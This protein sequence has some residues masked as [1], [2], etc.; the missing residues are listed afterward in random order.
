M[1]TSSSCCPVVELRQYTLHPGQREALIALFDRELVET[2]EAVGMRVI[3]QF[4]DIDRPDVFTWLRGFSDMP[5]RAAALQAFYDGPVWAAHRDAANRTKLTF[6]NVRLLRPALNGSGFALHGV[7]RP[8]HGSTAVPRELIVCSICTLTAPAAA[9]FSDLF[10]REI[11]PVLAAHDAAPLAVL[12]TE[13]SPNTFPRLPVREGEHSFL[14]FT[15]FADV[16]A[17]D[18]HVARRERSRDWSEAVRPLLDHHLRAPMEI[19]RLSPT[20]RSCRLGGPA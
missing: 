17:Y 13:P 6:D 1:S 10:A 4:R 9:G 7:E 14:W 8:P 3:A 5:A 12:E 2:Q 18:R 19:W 11:A 15:R 20:A 16:D